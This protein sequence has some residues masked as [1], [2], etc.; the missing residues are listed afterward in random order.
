MS[1]PGPALLRQTAGPAAVRL[2]HHQTC[3]K[4]H[5]M[6]TLMRAYRDL[7]LAIVIAVFAPRVLALLS[8]SALV[9]N[10]GAFCNTLPE[11]WPSVDALYFCVV[12]MATVGYGDLAPETLGGQVFT[13]GFLVLGIGIFVLTVGAF[14]EAMLAEMRLR[15]DLHR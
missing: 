1:L 4:G 15:R 3:R 8:I 9:A 12:S 6:L 14:A 11:N 2:L 7:F 13:I 5:P 10:V